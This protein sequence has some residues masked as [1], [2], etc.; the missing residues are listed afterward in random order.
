MN[1]IQ[2]LDSL[3]ASPPRQSSAPTE[4]RQDFT[5]SDEERDRIDKHARDNC[6]EANQRPSTHKSNN[7]ERSRQ[8]HEGGQ[9]AE[10]SE[11][12]FTRAWENERA[13][14]QRARGHTYAG[15]RLRL[16]RTRVCLR[17]LHAERVVRKNIPK[18]GGEDVNYQ[19][20]SACADLIG[21]RLTTAAK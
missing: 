2:F 3:L 20:S 17:L 1:V 12:A 5:E 15:R 13:P 7:S 8:R 18:I 10:L 19:L 9:E 6:T 14:C 16:H 21:K 11:T 4:A